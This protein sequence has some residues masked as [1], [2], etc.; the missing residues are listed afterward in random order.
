MLGGVGIF[1]I[2]ERKRLREKKQM[3]IVVKNGQ[4]QQR[5][6]P[7]ARYFG[8][9]DQ[10]GTYTEIYGP[11]PKGKYVETIKV[12]DSED[13]EHQAKALKQVFDNWLVTKARLKNTIRVLNECL[14]GIDHGRG[15]LISRIKSELKDIG[16]DLENPNP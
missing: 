3:A 6:P 4:A 10:Y 9:S 14:E 16:V 2:E 1:A 7:R 11:A 12:Y 8:L 15:Y 5:P 13:F